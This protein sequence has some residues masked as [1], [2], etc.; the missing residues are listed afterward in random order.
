MI[1]EEIAVLRS[2]LGTH[3]VSLWR[4]MGLP[5]P[6]PSKGHGFFHTISRTIESTYPQTSLPSVPG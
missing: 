6:D 2:V 3:G 1:Y 4:P 5:C